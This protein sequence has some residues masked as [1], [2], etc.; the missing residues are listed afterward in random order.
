[1]TR[2]PRLDHLVVA[3]ASL[4]AGVAE[5][6]ERVGVELEQG[7]RHERYGTHNAL[8]SLGPSAYLEVIAVDP[9]AP[10]PHGPRWFEL[11]SDE[12][13]ARLAVGAQL[14]HWV[15]AV[16]SLAGADPVHGEVVELSRGPNR[17]ALTV[18]PDGALPMGG[19]LPSLID[20]HTEPPAGRL[21]DRGVR[22]DALTLGTPETDL[23]R[24]RVDVLGLHDPPRV[25]ATASPSL[26]AVLRAPTGLITL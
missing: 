20:W 7:G 2:V 26:R 14:V 21:P 13:Q 5:V 8:L 24:K 11:G 22:L 25:V 16:A 1:V 18:P 19:V 17:W 23:L 12:M 3:A 9:D 10:A 15:V 4:D 6:G